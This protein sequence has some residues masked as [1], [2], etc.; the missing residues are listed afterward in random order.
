MT[1]LYIHGLNSTN[2]NL[3]TDWLKQYGK[4]LHPLMAYHNLP[5]DYQYLDKLVQHYK[6]EVIVGSSMGGYMAFHLGQYHHIPTI[7]LNPALIMT[8][9]IKPDNRQMAGDTIH[10]ISLGKNDEI[11]PPITTKLLLNQWQVP[12]HIFEYEMGH[13]TDFKIFKEV[14][15][16]SG[17]FK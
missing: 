14:C 11:I 9:I 5:L 1:S 15:L 12:H 8:N 4:V 16:K 3:R 17:L 6:P 13:E 2:V 7:L 10:Y